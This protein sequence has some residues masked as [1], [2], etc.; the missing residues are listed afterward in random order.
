[1]STK[2]KRK[3]LKR[4]KPST[5]PRFAVGDRVRVKY[6]VLD[7][8]FP[9][10]PLGG[11]AGTV[12][13]VN[14]DGKS[15]LYLIEWNRFTLDHMHPVFR[16]RCERD[17]LDVESYRLDEAEL[18]PD[19]GDRVPLEQ[20]SQIVTRPLS[21]TD[22]DDRIR[23]I[24]GLT[25]DDPLPES[26]YENLHH[27][28]AYLAANLTFPFDAGYWKD[29][30]PFESSRKCKVN[31]VALADLDCY[32]SE[33][34]GLLFQIRRDAEQP[35]VVQAR[36]KSRSGLFGFLSNLLGFSAAPPVVDEGDFMPLDDLEFTKKD[37]NQRLFKDFSYWFW[38][39]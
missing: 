15:H 14:H 8:D 12:T 16:K 4:R 39:H 24:F 5:P 30:G 23:A 25:S 26:S 18:E 3:P 7:A 37:A 22:Q 36:V 9:D 13:E 10:V 20:P 2:K 19:A 31:V 29:A 27:Y 1:M 28:H 11:W 35:K 32:C 38:N 33:G 17:G 21:T 34:V 6:G